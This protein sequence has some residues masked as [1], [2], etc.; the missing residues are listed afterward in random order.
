MNIKDKLFNLFKS[1]SDEFYS[2]EEEQ[3]KRRTRAI[4]A[5]VAFMLGLPAIPAFID[6]SGAAYEAIKN[7]AKFEDK[8]I[9]K[10]DIKPIDTEVN[11]QSLWKTKQERR[12]DDLKQEI[13]DV[14]KKT[15]IAI[16]KVEKSAV[17][18]K[19]ALDQVV[20][21]INKIVQT[22]AS[23]NAKQLES[24]DGKLSDIKKDLMAYTDESVKNTRRGSL[25]GTVTA[26]PQA[27]FIAQSDSNGTI[28]ASIPMRDLS[29]THQEQEVEMVEKEVEYSMDSSAQ[30]T[31]EI[32][33]LER[34][35]QNDS[36]D[37]GEFI[38]PMGAAKGVV[39]TGGNLKTLG[40]GE[41]KPKSIFIK[42]VDDFISTNDTR[43]SMKGCVMEGGAVGDFGTGIAE[44]RMKSIQCTAIGSDGQEY[45]AVSEKVQAWVFDES[46]LYGIESRVVTKEGEIF[47]KSLPLALL[48][49]AMNM[50]VA[51][52]QNSAV[53][54]NNGGVATS[55]STGGTTTVPMQVPVSRTVTAETQT[56]M[57]KITDLWLKYLDTLTPIVQY[58]AGRKVTVAFSGIVKMK[59]QKVDFFDSQDPINLNE[60]K[61][62][63]NA[64]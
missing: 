5:A 11:K 1:P 6:G 30:S 57:G 18:T 63:R 10:E 46:N 21:D 33:T 59:W 8:K 12:T 54:A 19:V 27:P 28:G 41:S 58:R 13:V 2:V 36:K 32:S 15:D 26:L 34:Y 62:G 51:S 7:N 43:L 60:P 37:L 42:I 16:E 4:I 22:S 17:D 48:S 38:I 45:L 47:A 3:K 55:Y 9:E 20:I 25:S 24:Y 64:L 52:A 40:S 23:E 44:V 53:S 56:I 14:S 31:S 50:A 39:A 61:E 29:A 35:D 49:T